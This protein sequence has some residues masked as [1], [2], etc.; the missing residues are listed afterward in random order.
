MTLF[1]WKAPGPYRIAFSSRLGGVSEGPF[2]SLNL[3]VLTDDAP[4]TSARTGAGSVRSSASTR[5]QRRWP[6]N[7]TAPTSCGQTGAGS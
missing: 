5:R 6:G 3:G 7:T 1:E 4:D 2:A